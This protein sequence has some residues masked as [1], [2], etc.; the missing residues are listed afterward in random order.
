[1]GEAGW[2]MSRLTLD[3]RTSRISEAQFAKFF[4]VSSEHSLRCTRYE[5]TGMDSAEW[6]HEEHDAAGG[7][8]YRYV[9]SLAFDGSG[10][11]CVKYGPDGDLIG[12]VRIPIEAMLE[13]DSKGFTNR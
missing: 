7:L 4:G 6:Q 2:T 10:S 12:E 8:L 5:A 13:A 3:P 1:M 11:S 9:T